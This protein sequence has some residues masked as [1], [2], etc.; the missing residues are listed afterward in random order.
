MLECLLYKSFLFFFCCTGVTTVCDMGSIG[1][2]EE[3]WEDLEQVYMA[4][5]DKAELPIR[6]FAMV[7]LPTWYC[8]ASTCFSLQAALH[9]MSS[10]TFS[11]LGMLATTCM[12]SCKVC[13]LIHPCGWAEEDAG[14]VLCFG[15]FPSHCVHLQA[16]TDSVS[17]VFVR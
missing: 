14:D 16:L 15:Q 8:L 1:E 11:D 2:T 4:A 17:L 7:P 13:V 5:A 9:S 3:V 12:Y 10:D 6:V